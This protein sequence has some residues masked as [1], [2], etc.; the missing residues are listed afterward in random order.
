MCYEL[1]MDRYEIISL[2]KVKEVLIGLLAF[3]K[4]EYNMNKSAI[5]TFLTC[6]G[7]V[8]VVA[9][10]IAAVKSAPKA[11]KL[12]EEAEHEKEVPLTK[13]EKVKAAAP[14]Y[15]PAI[16]VGA[17]TIACIFG[18]NVLNKQS[19]ASLASAYALLSSSYQEYKD[20]V[21]ELY[22]EDADD[23]VKD[24]IV[25]DHYEESEYDIPEGEQLFFDFNTLQYFTST[26]DKVLQK[27]TMEDGLECY[28]ISTPDSPYLD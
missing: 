19:Q 16:V 8:G 13:F 18:A 14:A 22:G 25:K 1:D 2:N 23:R 7:A 10:S 4:G 26:M 20:K 6:L 27:V 12:I 9:T 28:I 11:K 21:V 5:S 17:S 24:E 15:I 3:S